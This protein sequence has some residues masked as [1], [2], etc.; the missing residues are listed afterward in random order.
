MRILSNRRSNGKR[1]LL[2]LATLTLFMS[3]RS[4]IA[5]DTSWDGGVNNVWAEPNNWNPGLPSTSNT[6]FITSG[7]SGSNLFLRSGSNG[8]VDAG[9]IVFNHS[10]YRNIFPGSS[11]SAASI[12]FGSNANL[13]INISRAVTI[14]DP[15]NANSALAGTLTLNIPGTLNVRCKSNGNLYFNPLTTGSG[16]VVYSRTSGSGTVDARFLLGQAA[17]VTLYQHLP[18]DYTGGTQINSNVIVKVAQ[19]TEMDGTDVENGPLGTSTIEMA[20]GT[21]AISTKSLGSGSLIFG[22]DFQVSTDS[23]F[24]M[25]GAHGIDVRM[26]GAFTLG[27]RTLTIYSTGLVFD[28]AIWNSGDTGAVAFGTPGSFDEATFAVSAGQSA[29]FGGRVGEGKA[30]TP[31]R[32]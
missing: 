17:P 20:G 28:D 31:T 5:V 2:V 12:S 16:S 14:A 7:G 18:S 21:F 3:E 27:S 8:T 25:D 6:A 11:V 30:S 15:G 22:N 29:D 4:S 19:P 23:F 9:T 24:D 10:S 26:G 1:N 13:D 32:F